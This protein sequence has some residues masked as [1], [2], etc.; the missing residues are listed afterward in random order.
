MT[1]C[2]E[3]AEGDG[4]EEL[5]EADEAEGKKI[6]KDAF[7]EAKKDETTE[8]DDVK[9]FLTSK[10]ADIEKVKKALKKPEAKKAFDK[11]VTFLEKYADK[12]EELDKKLDNYLSRADEASGKKKKS[13]VATLV[14][15]LVRCLLG[16][17]SLV[18]K[19]VGGTGKVAAFL[20]GII[21]KILCS[22]AA[23]L[24]SYL[25]ESEGDGDDAEGSDEVNEASDEEEAGVDAEGNDTEE[26]TADDDEETDSSLTPE[27]KAELKGAYTKAFKKTLAQLKYTKSVDDLSVAEKAEFWRTLGTIWM[28]EAPSQF[29]TAKEQAALQK[30]VVKK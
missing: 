11:I 2:N 20:L 29:L 8:P 28:Q 10:K 22:S 9:K 7:D 23:K 14:R 30:I 6:A 25:P 1:E 3:S 19:I 15:G 5:T 24:D 17:I 18:G 4:E 26:T 27:K 12:D 13:P 21:E 16:C